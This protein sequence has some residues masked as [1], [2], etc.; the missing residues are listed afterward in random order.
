M[1]DYRHS[2]VARCI[3]RT[4]GDWFISIYDHQHSQEFGVLHASLVLFTLLTKYKEW[5]H[6]AL[7]SCYKLH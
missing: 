7:S 4:I 6:S 5:Y 3:S 2:M 1:V